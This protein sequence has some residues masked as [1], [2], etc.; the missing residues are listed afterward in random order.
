MILPL[1]MTVQSWL[2][3]RNVEP[4]SF[5][6]QMLLNRQI[7]QATIEDRTAKDQRIKF[8]REEAKKIKG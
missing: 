8:L 7:K 3:E 5:Y 4:T 2:A 1:T 6:D